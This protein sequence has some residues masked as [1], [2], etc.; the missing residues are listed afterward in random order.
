MLEP[1]AI[2]FSSEVYSIEAIKK[3]AYRFSD[4]LSIDIIPG[5]SEI[6][7]TLHF[8]AEPKDELQ[9]QRIIA[10]FKTRT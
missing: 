3:A 10:D 6:E 1:R 8:L 5:S 9:S 4:M 7:C 2:V